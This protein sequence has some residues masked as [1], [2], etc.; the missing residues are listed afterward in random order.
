MNR[1][2]TSTT[3]RLTTLVLG[4][5]ALAGTSRAATIYWDGGAIPTSTSW[6]NAV[7]WS[8]DVLPGS[9]DTAVISA[10]PSSAVISLDAPQSV[11][12]LSLGQ[13]T[14]LTIGNAN[15]LSSG[16]TLTLNHFY[17]GNGIYN[18]VQTLAANAVLGTASSIWNLDNINSAA[19]FK[20]TGTISG[21]ASVTGGALAWGGLGRSPGRGQPGSF[22]RV[23]PA[24]F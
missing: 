2:R 1:N 12:F 24:R 22:R 13:S 7:N 5:L 20:V 14:A 23:D 16:N 18:N 17:R 10:A 21:N 15:D 8:G 3:R 11:G 4:A 9:G 6:N 19:A